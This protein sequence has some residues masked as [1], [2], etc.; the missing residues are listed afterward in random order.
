MVALVVVALRSVT[1]VIVED[2]TAAV[3]DPEIWNAVVVAD[4]EVAFTVTRFVIVDVELFTR[5]AALIVCWAV[6][7][8]AFPTFKDATTAPVVGE[9]VRD[10]S[11]A[12][13]DETP[14]AR[15]PPL[16]AKHPPVRL[17]PF[18]NV[19]EALVPCTSMALANAAPPVVVVDT[20]TPKPFETRSWE[21]EAAVV[22]AR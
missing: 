13:T 18:A 4:V 5:S 20:P 2:A 14:R 7:V 15:H 1:F 8:L 12:E 6:H 11:P 10:V 19:D 17:M 3:N 9:I 16:S 21:V 22:T